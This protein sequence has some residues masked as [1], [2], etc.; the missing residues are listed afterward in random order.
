MRRTTACLQVV[1][2]YLYAFRRNSLLKSTPQ[3]QIA[4]KTIKPLFQK[5]KVIQG[6][7]CSH[8]QKACH[9]CLLW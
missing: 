6:H 1:L 7:R 3:P 9:Y 8:E 2:I 5:F 4:K